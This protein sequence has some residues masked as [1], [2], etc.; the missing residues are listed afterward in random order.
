M[1]RQHVNA[2][3]VKKNWTKSPI[4]IL[5]WNKNELDCY[6]GYRLEAQ[7]ASIFSFNYVY[8]MVAM[9]REAMPFFTLFAPHIT[10]RVLRM[11]WLSISTSSRLAEPKM[12]SNTCETAKETTN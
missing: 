12:I 1:E 4:F 7:W 11:R 6:D 3:V 5:V 9:K 10:A 2:H 8:Q